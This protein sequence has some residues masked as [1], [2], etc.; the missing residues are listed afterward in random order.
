MKNVEWEKAFVALGIP[1]MIG[2]AVGQNYHSIFFGV[3]AWFIS[4]WFIS[5]IYGVGG[6]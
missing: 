4:L 5:S 2:I 1:I 3:L 6:F